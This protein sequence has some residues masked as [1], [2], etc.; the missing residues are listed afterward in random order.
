MAACAGAIVPDVEE[1]QLSQISTSTKY[2]GGNDVGFARVLGQCL[3]PFAN[4]YSCLGFINDARTKATRQIPTE[5]VDLHAAI[6][7]RH[8]TR[9]PSSLDT[10]TSSVP[11][12]TPTSSPPTPVA[13][14]TATAT[15]RP[16]PTLS[17]CAPP[18]G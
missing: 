8:R 6:R 10:R 16:S 11:A 15:V 17:V 5:L 12:D 2:V 7:K 14:A 9:E 18:A 1:G 3:L 4:H 13:T